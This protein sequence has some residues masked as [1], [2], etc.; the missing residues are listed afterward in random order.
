M[1]DYGFFRV[2]AAVPRVR[3]ADV[4]YNKE[5][6]CALIDKAEND[7]V[8]LL[9]F[10]ELCVTGYTCADLFA[11]QKLIDAAEKAV[12]GIRNHT[13]GRYVTVI[14]GAPVRFRGRLYNCAIVIRNGNIKGI[15]PKI[16]L[17]NYAEFY[18]S[19]WFSSGSDFLSG[20]SPVGAVHDD[21]K[22]SYRPGFEA[23]IKYAGFRTNI[24]PSQLF[25]IGK[26]TVA[27]EICEDLWTPVPPSSWHAVAGAEVI[28]N[29]S[30]SNELLMKHLYRKSLVSNQSARTISA[31][32][33]SSCGW[34]ESTQDLVFAGSSMIYENGRLMAE[35]ERFLSDDSIIEADVDIEKLQTLRQKETT[36][37]AASPDGST[38]REYFP[39]YNRVELGPASPTDFEAKLLRKVEPHPFVPGGDKAEIDRRSREITSIQVQ[40]LATRLE[41]IGCKT[42]VI[43][44]SGGLDSTLALLITVMAFDKLG[45][46]RDRIVGVTMPGFGTTD[47]TYRNAV[48]LMKSLGV[49]LKEISIVPSV[50]QHFKDIGQNPD[51]HDVTYENCQARE[52]TQ[53]L[54]DIANKTGGIVVGTGDLSELAL[55]WCTYNGDHMSMYAVNAGIPKTLVKYLVKWAAETRFA[56]EAEVKATLLD[57]VDTPISP[58]LTPPDKKGQIQQK[59][60]DLVGPYELHDFF[61]Y[62]FFRFGYSPAKILFLA[63]KAFLGRKADA[64]VFIGPE[65]KSNVYDEETIRKWLKKFMWR[66]FSQQFKR[67]CLPDCPKVGTVTLSP[68]GDWRMPSDAKSDLFYNDI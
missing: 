3:L 20:K 30:A 68:R 7:Q 16:W 6:I 55:G 45:W 23:E 31:Y 42:A 67:S 48:S 57:V 8:S 13:K 19:R 18:E 35:N 21:G 17:P 65:G 51:N 5:R 34:G 40:G 25:T 43:G 66:F 46:K 44:I 9:A 59:T 26:A 54:M 37:D 24:S 39:L 15:V 58:E 60:E 27:I 56:D 11:Q 4:E 61:L 22:D 1:E 64:S 41:H 29:L 53:I 14:I 47:R 10:P 2:A 49:T 50:T 36:F 32:V 63:K 12:A 38:S 52:R 33:Y 62:N 28:V